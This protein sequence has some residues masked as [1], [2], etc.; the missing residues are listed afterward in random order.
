MSLSTRLKAARESTGKNQKEFAKLVGA[1]FRAWQDY[2]A[3]ISTPGGKVFESLARLKI[4]TN[5][6][7][8]GEGLM[9][10]GEWTRGN[11]HSDSAT[12][13][14]V[15]PKE[16]ANGDDL[17]GLGYIQVPR[18]DI[19]A[20]AGGGAVVHSEQV[21][22]YLAFRPE[23]VQDS[24]RVDPRNLALIRVVGDS[25]EPTMF[26]DDL[27][28]VDTS[29]R[30]LAAN[31]IYVLQ[32]MGELLVKRIQSHLDGTVSIISDNTLYAPE[33]VRGENL[34]SLNVVGR[35]VWYGR[36]A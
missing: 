2:E 7:L 3:G 21:V 17:P 16:G 14:G 28:L 32:F 18:Y 34:N 1:S 8:T 25:M 23:W 10:R 13:V 9:K 26:P 29:Q 15:V 30:A 19:A 35:V 22:D 11:T 24:L 5:W 4:N 6:L 33:T 36:R 31:A 12:V 20:S 27:V